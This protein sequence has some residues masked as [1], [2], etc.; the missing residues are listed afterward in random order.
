MKNQRHLTTLSS[1]VIVTLLVFTANSC[2]D[3]SADRIAEL[4]SRIEHMEDLYKPGLHSLMNETMFRHANL[5]FA[6]IAENWELAYYQHHELEEVFEDIEA[7]HPEYHG[8]PIALLIGSMTK[9]AMDEVEEAIEAQNPVRFREAFTNLTES[10]NSC[11]VA[12]NKQMIYIIEPDQNTVR[13][14]RF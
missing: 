12:T 7:L 8:E 2:S 3:G 13:N 4:E 1:L 9:P 6:G 5:W 11:H 14:L 10:C